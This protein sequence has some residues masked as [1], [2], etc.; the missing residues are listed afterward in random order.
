MSFAEE[1]ELGI[2][3]SWTFLK[4]LFNQN[5]FDVF[6]CVCVW[7]GVCVCACRHEH[8][9]IITNNAPFGKLV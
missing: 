7:V 6:A 4:S 8:K 3:R 9:Y 5:L 2:I 1:D